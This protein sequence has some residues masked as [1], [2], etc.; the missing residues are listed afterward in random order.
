MPELELEKKEIKAINFTFDLVNS[1]N[2]KQTLKNNKE[3]GEVTEKGQKSLK[4]EEIYHIYKAYK[5]SKDKGSFHNFVENQPDDSSKEEHPSEK[6]GK[7]N[8]VLK[9]IKILIG[10]IK[11]N[12]VDTPQN[13]KTQVPKMPIPPLQNH[14]H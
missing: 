10:E 5:D 14:L 1:Y 6:K 11:R 12:P 7:T 2:H 9:A 4:K 8:E 13:I 3:I